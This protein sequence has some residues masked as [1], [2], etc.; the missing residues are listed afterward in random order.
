MWEKK[1]FIHEIALQINVKNES[2]MKKMALS[3]YFLY[4]Y[5]ILYLWISVCI[6][7]KCIINKQEAYVKM[8]I[9]I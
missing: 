2:D 4:F 3:F 7:K 1:E 9:V 8:E 6:W 5:V